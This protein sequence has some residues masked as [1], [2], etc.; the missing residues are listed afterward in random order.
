MPDE[1]DAGRRWVVEPPGPGEVSLHMAVGEGVDLTA[2]QEAALS[3]LVRSLESSD[4]E[5]TG[6]DVAARCGAF[7]SCT[8]KQ[9][10]PVRCST[11]VCKGL[12]G[13][14]A[15]TQSWNLMGTFTVQ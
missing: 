14:T 1:S 11:F 8:G 10:N 2:G 15:E 3:E 9:C 12:V 13:V 5:V 6:H 4:A 7:S